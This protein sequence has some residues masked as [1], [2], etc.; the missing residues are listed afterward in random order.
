M[1]SKVINFFPTLKYRVVS[2]VTILIIFFQRWNTAWSVYSPYNFCYAGLSYQM[3]TYVVIRSSGG[4]SP[5]VSPIFDFIP[6]FSAL[7]EVDILLFQFKLFW[8]LKL[9]SWPRNWPKMS[10]KSQNLRKIQFFEILTIF[11]LFFDIESLKFQNFWS[12]FTKFCPL[13]TRIGLGAIWSRT[14]GLVVV[15]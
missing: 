8:I 5:P 1:V 9:V 15:H 7:L 2:K 4:R 11:W 6:S 10:K 13:T 3:T 14:T 12:V